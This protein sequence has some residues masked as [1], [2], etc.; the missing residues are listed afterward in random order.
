MQITLNSKVVNLLISI[1]FNSMVEQPTQLAPERM[2]E[3]WLNFKQELIRAMQPLEI[4]PD[5]L[6]LLRQNIVFY[7]DGT[8]VLIRFLQKDPIIDTLAE[9]IK[10]RVKEF[11]MNYDLG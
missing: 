3:M 6:Y 11:I 2:T 7:D 4:P 10:P 1:K 9:H 5:F 8:G